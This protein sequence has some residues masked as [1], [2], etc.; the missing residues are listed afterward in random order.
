MWLPVWRTGRSRVVLKPGQ[1][2][3]RS[4][5]VEFSSGKNLFAN[6]EE[7]D[8]SRPVSLFKVTS[9]CVLDHRLEVLPVVALGEDV[10]P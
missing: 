4:N 8:H 5:L 3:F 2:D 10:V 1:A 7:P 6:E 9:H